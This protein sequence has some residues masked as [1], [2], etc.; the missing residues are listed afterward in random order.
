[1]DT[2]RIYVGGQWVRSSGTELIDVVN[3]Y[4][5]Q[6]I[7]Q[8]P[9]GAAGDVDVA[10]AAARKALDAWSQT[11]VGERA[12]YLA[13]AAGLLGD[14]TDA[15]AEV[16]TAEMG[17]PLKIAKLVQIGTPIGSRTISELPTSVSHSKLSANRA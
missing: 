9:A 7:G 3:P 13:K 2:N 1:M 10:V 15:L 11:D 16:V 4:T 5:E 17:C 12:A 14:R 8:V 6:V